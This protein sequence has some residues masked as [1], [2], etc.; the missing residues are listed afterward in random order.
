[1]MH[2]KLI[3]AILKV[4]ELLLSGNKLGVEHVHLLG[5]QEI[6]TRAIHLSRR[7]GLSP[8]GGEG[9]FVVRLEV[10]V[11]EFPCLRGSAAALFDG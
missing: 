3:V 10:W 4:L 5:G 11:L 8:N 6:F 2:A 7:G 1:M 9:I